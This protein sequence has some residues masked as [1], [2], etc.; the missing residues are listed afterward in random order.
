MAATTLFP[1]FHV[2]YFKTEIM[3]FSCVFHALKRSCSAKGK[4]F[5]LLPPR[6][7]Y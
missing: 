4:Q 7:V 6:N 3:Q 1:T 5:F 2:Q